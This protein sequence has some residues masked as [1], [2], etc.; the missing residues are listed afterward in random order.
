MEEIKPLL[1]QGEEILWSSSPG[2][3]AKKPKIVHIIVFY[4]IFLIVINISCLISFLFLI[5]PIA[6]I[7]LIPSSCGTVIGIFFGYKN[8]KF[9]SEFYCIS[10]HKIYLK[11][12]MKNKFAWP[13]SRYRY[14][15]PTQYGLND[16]NILRI[17]D[18][19]ARGEIFS[20][21]IDKIELVKIKTSSIL[22]Y[23]DILFVFLSEDDKLFFAS[24]Y[25]VTE[26]ENFEAILNKNLG[27]LL[28]KRDEKSRVYSR[29]LE[30]AEEKLS[31][32]EKGFTNIS[33]WIFPLSCI[34]AGFVIIL[35]HTSSIIWS[36]LSLF[37]GPI[38]IFYGFVKL[39]YK[40]KMYVSI[41]ELF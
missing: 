22:K 10:S 13:F 25:Q 29:G 6:I 4:I 40:V 23:E 39:W 36:I 41:V 38:L 34:I 17:K 33:N 15:P 31:Q 11:S 12:M 32:L 27:F 9:N 7:I 30:K 2:E 28:I 14:Y 19:Q 18:F 3:D 37:I 26:I 21:D 5:I 1:D 35:I 8:I 24:F 16:G 20:I